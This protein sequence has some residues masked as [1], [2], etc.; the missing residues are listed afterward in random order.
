[1]FL[2]PRQTAFG[3]IPIV[4][5]LNKRAADFSYYTVMTTSLTPCKLRSAPEQ[6]CGIWGAPGRRTLQVEAT[7]GSLGVQWNCRYRIEYH[8][9]NTS[10]AADR[11]TAVSR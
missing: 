4:F 10:V 3:D 8:T 2:D 11:E 1:M 5:K 9:L 7:Q 6:A